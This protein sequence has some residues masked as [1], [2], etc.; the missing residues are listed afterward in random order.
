MYSVS[1]IQ[2]ARCLKSQIT[3]RIFQTHLNVYFLTEFASK[4]KKMVPEEVTIHR[5]IIKGS[6]RRRSMA[7]AHIWTIV[8]MLSKIRLICAIVQRTRMRWSVRILLI[9]GVNGRRSS[10]KNHLMLSQMELLVFVILVAVSISII[11]MDGLLQNT[12][13]QE[14]WIQ[15]QLLNFIPSQVILNGVALGVFKNKF[16]LK[17]MKSIYS[18]LKT[19]DTNK[20][21][22]SKT[23]I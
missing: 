1:K 14:I 9:T 3:Y 7:S 15:V 12:Y 2:V 11:K 8:G 22:Q 19:T 21:T 10:M 23:S 18:Y 16:V 20:F 4:V 17:M 6:S 5:Q 13:W